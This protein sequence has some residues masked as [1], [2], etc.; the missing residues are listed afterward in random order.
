MLLKICIFAVLFILYEIYWPEKLHMTYVFSFILPSFL[1]LAISTSV[2]N[3]FFSKILLDH[4]HWHKCSLQSYDPNRS[5]ALSEIESWNIHARRPCLLDL[6]QTGIKCGKSSNW[7]CDRTFPQWMDARGLGSTNTMLTE[8]ICRLPPFLHNCTVALGCGISRGNDSWIW[9]QSH[10]AVC[11]TNIIWEMRTKQ[12]GIHATSLQNTS[13][14][15]TLLWERIC[16][17]ESEY[18]RTRSLPRLCLDL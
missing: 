4:F 14:M 18:E 3:N 15:K 13:T 7:T 1:P 9:H 11:F 16:T 6:L 8:A 12:R 2:P 17:L 5:L 10:A